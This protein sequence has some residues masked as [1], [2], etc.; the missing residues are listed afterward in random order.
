MVKTGEIFV[1]RDKDNRLPRR[2]DD[3]WLTAYLSF[4]HFDSNAAVCVAGSD[5]NAVPLHCSEVKANL[6]LCTDHKISSCSTRQ[7]NQSVVAHE[8]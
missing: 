3:I 1:H 4:I 6:Q 8:Y 2:D 5:D 7:L